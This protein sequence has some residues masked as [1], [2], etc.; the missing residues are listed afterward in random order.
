MTVFIALTVFGGG[1]FAFKKRTF[2]VFALAY[3]SA[4]VYFMPAYFGFT[5]YNGTSF[6]IIDET[7][8]IYNL[9]LCVI[10]FGGIL[11]DSF[12]NRSFQQHRLFYYDKGQFE[13]IAWISLIISATACI[14]TIIASPELFDFTNTTNPVFFPGEAIDTIAS[15]V[16]AEIFAVGSWPLLITFLL[17]A[18]VF[19]Y[20]YSKAIL[21]TH[22]PLVRT[23]FT[24]T[25][26]LRA[27]KHL[28]YHSRYG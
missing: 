15:N 9:V 6:Q 22:K 25:V 5:V 11:N 18:L 24:Y 4:V 27:Q 23:M 10:I 16:F 12:V 1:Y 13:K 7:Y 17:F 20:S 26:F 28:A 3:F 19:S 8:L 21:R 14:L 2:D